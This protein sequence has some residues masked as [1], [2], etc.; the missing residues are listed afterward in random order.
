MDTLH[1][2]NLHQLETFYSNDRMQALFSSNLVHFIG[3]GEGGGFGWR[4]C[5]SSFLHYFE[6]IITHNEDINCGF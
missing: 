3:G 2:E 6:M 1:S 5:L 4:V